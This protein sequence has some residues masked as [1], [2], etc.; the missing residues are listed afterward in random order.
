MTVDAHAVEPAPLL[1]APVQ[2]IKDRAWIAAWWLGGRTLVLA[3]ALV[4]HVVRPRGYSSSASHAH[5]FGL[6]TGWD[7]LWYRRIAAAGYLLIPNRQSDPAFFP[8]Y[9]LLLRGAHFFGIGY[10]TA[11]LLLSNLALLVALVAFEAL[12]R[13]LFSST[14]ARRATTYVAIFPLGY[15][16]SMAYPE[17]IVLGAIALA[18][19]AA[20]RGRW[21]AA[22][23]F[24]AAAALARPEGVLVALPLLA[25]AWQSRDRLTPLGRGVALGAVVAPMTALAS[26]PA[27]LGSVLHDPL[28]WNEAER[29][30][31]RRFSPLG[32]ADTITR[33]PHTLAGN[34]WLA[35]DAICFVVYLALLVAAR[36]AGTSWPWLAGAAMNDGRSRA[37]A[38]R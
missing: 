30:W 14:F 38:R 12:T 22:A 16:F 21:Q 28:A 34:A 31:G 24:A 15:V 17:S 32:F 29:A 11:G 13:A 7:G 25:I 20:V 8:L 23:V 3:T 6:L 10:L 27:Y 18:A 1:A 36:R 33:L 19:L 4:I 35:R 5:A 9:P 26:Y 37:R 2:W